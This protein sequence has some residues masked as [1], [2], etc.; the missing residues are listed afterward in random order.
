MFKSLI[1]KVK[2][3]MQ[4]MGLIKNIKSVSNIQAL[5]VDDDFYQLIENVWLPLYQGYLEKYKDESYHKVE[6]T[7]IGG[8][9]RTRRMHTLG[10]P[11]IVSKEMASLIF[12][13]KC[14]INISDESLSDDIEGVFKYNKFYKLFQNHLEYMFALGG[15]VL[16]TYV[17]EDRTGQKRVK[18]S[19]VTAECFIPLAYSNDDITEGVFLT[20]SKKGDKWYTLLEWHQ[21]EGKTYVIRNQLFQSEDNNELGTEVTLE[22]LYPDLA[23][24]ATIKGLSRPLFV[25]IKPN[26]ANNI[27]LQSPLGISLY[28]NAI[29][30]IKALDTAFDSYH[31]EF[32]LGKKRIIVPHTAV[33]TVVDRETEEVHRY[34][35]ANDEVYEAFNFEDL[36]KQQIVDNSI[37][38]RVEEHI[39]AIQSLLDVLAMQTGFSP[40][41]FSFDGQGVKTATEV[42]SENSKTYQTKNSHEN[43]IEEGIINLVTSICEIATLY[44]VFKV[45]EKY[46]VTVD[47]DDSIAEDRDAN[48]TYYLKI[49]NNQLIPKYMALMR[50]LKVPEEQAKQIIQEAKEEA[51]TDLPDVDQLYGGGA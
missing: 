47:F 1:A 46:E 32:K 41:V 43:V 21:W 8:G 11:K 24:M 2:A 39:K 4:K 27:D 29:D 14:K 15:I 6:Y 38:L 45:P 17:E 50:I 44:N 26:I 42:V 51:A 12:N 13:E 18:I 37:E 28:A 19:Y 34:F 40:G 9:R 16:K 5:P 49:M 31:R 36:D 7:T 10:M 35:D 22:T 48:A 20:V 25:Y 3:V 23:K 30:T 33:R